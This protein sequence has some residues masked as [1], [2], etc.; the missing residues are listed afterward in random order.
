MPDSSRFLTAGPD[1]LVHMFDST[2]RELQRWKRPLPVQDMAVS[3]DG[4]YL[5]LACSSDRKLQIVRCGGRAPAGA[6]FAA[7]ER[8]GA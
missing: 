6:G 8:R 2:G 4:A 7:D 1:K 3:P 5:V